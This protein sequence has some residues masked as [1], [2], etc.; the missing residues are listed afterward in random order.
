LE[1]SPAFGNVF[2]KLLI[3]SDIDMTESIALLLALLNPFLLV[4]YL[5]GPM[6]S[7]NQGQFN[8]VL[9]RAGIIAASVF[10][11]FSV[12]GDA[13]FSRVVMADFASFQIFGGIIFVVIGLQFV[14]KGP[15]AIELLKG[16]ASHISGA[17]AMPVLTRISH[18]FPTTTCCTAR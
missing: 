3:C 18:G 2:K 11:A 12:L 17:I 13:I 7:L 4:V 1:H 15:G 10:C 6:K 8:H 5:V 14:F 9:L 16:E